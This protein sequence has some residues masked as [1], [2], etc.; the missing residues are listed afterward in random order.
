MKILFL[1]WDSLCKGFMKQ[2][3]LKKGYDVVIFPFSRETEDTKRSEKLTVSITEELVKGN[4]DY[5]FSFNYFPVAAI[6]CKA[7]RVTY[8]SWVYDSPFIQLYSETIKYDT[9]RV[10]IFD[11]AE[12][13]CLRKYGVETVYY[14]PMAAPSEY[15]KGLVSKASDTG[16]YQCDVAFVGST[17]TEKSH[18]KFHYLDKLDEYTKGYLEGVMQAQKKIYG[19]NFVEETLTPAI[20]ENMRKV[21]PLYNSGD[22]FETVEWVFATYFIDQR[23]TAME[24]FEILD[25][26]SKEYDVQLYTPEP[27]PN[28]PNVKNMGEVNPYT[29]A[30]LVFNTAKI[31]LNISLRSIVNG[32]PLRGLDIMGSGGFLL[33]NYQADFLEHFVPDEDYVY[34]D[35]YEDLMGKVEYYLSHEKER[36]EIAENGLQKI[37]RSHTYDKRIEEMFGSD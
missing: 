37:C 1:E 32:I 26:L 8:V 28:L 35:S 19:F 33:T 25:M 2:A 12:Y 23:I 11:S 22:G 20:M 31:N 4:Y 30:P 7:C 6:A 27:T 24:R 21:C 10:F 13:L 34:Y 14:L 15:Y 9:N 29:E 18:Y 5:V 3:L 17:Y 16:K 36:K